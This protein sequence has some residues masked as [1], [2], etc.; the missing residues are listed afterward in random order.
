MRWV[1]LE[2]TTLTEIRQ[3]QKAEIKTVDIIKMKVE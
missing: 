3:A 1:E 2:D